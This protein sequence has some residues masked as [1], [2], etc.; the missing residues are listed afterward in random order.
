[1]TTNHTQSLSKKYD[2]FAVSNL[3]AFRFSEVTEK[4]ADPLRRSSRSGAL[5]LLLV[6][7]L[8]GMVVTSFVLAALSTS[9]ATLIRNS[10]G[11]V[12]PR[13]DEYGYSEKSRGRAPT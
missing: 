7:S 6:A 1:M 3:R 13:R 8:S 10:S 4:H 12:F 9:M 11:A 2:I 5:S